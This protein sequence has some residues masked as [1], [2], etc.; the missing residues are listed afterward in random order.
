MHSS[1]E[2]AKK[3]SPVY[4]MHDWLS[5]FQRARRARTYTI[6]GQKLT[7]TPY[8]TKEFKYNEFYDLKALAKTIMINRTVDEN[9]KQVQWLK[10]KRIKYVK[11]ERKKIFFNYDMSE[12]F[13]CLD[14]TGKSL[15]ND[16]PSISQNKTASHTYCTRTKKNKS[17]LQKANNAIPQG[18]I[19]PDGLSNLYNSPLP[20]SVSKKKD[21]VNLCKKGVIPEELH[22]WFANLKTDET[23]IDR[24]P[25]AAYGEDSSS[26]SDE[27]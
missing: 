24:L 12:K 9:G 25:E 17:Q 7:K 15:K 18:D 14:I 22:G 13:H 8:K 19:L 11:G 6:K 20:I 16:V 3:N 27:N 26:E 23:L 21:L 10:I 2:H 4:S 5:I 1:I